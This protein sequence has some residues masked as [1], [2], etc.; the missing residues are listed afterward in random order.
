[1]LVTWSAW[2]SF[3]MERIL[4]GYHSIIQT[5]KD[6]NSSETET[7]EDIT[8]IDSQQLSVCGNP[9]I[10][11][12][13]SL[14]VDLP[15]FRKRRNAF[16]AFAGMF[17]AQPTSP[18]SSSGNQNANAGKSK[19]AKNQSPNNNPFGINLQQRI[20]GGNEA[21]PHSWPW[22]A[23]IITGS[24]IFSFA[25]SCNFGN[26]YVGDECWKRFISVTTSVQILLKKSPT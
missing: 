13:P 2:K 24:L 14:F 7:T 19:N 1:M 26:I 12:N 17:G 23:Q 6:E 8:I 16:G 9:Q 15:N 4:T 20:I 11:H 18:I 10:K 5:W 22:A 21:N 3:F 25:V